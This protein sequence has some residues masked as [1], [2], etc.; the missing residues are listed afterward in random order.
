MLQSIQALSVI[1][2]FILINGAGLVIAGVIL[3][4]YDDAANARSNEAALNVTHG[5]VLRYQGVLYIGDNDKAVDCY[6]H[7]GTNAVYYKQGRQ[8][9]SAISGRIVSN[10]TAYAGTY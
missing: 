9:R 6:R 3:S 10:E 8:Y 2:L 4:Y 7:C 5:D 1:L